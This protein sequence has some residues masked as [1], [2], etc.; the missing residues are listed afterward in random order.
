MRAVEATVVVP[1][2]L[3][4]VEARW[5]DTA[6]WADWVDGLDE[7]LEVTGPWP[8]AG[9]RVRW[10]SAPTGRGEVTEQ[11]LEHA[12]GEGQLSEVTDATAAGRQSVG[13]AE[14]G[15][16]VAVSLRLAYRVSRRSPLTPL[17]ELLFVSRAFRSSLESTL[18]R[19]ASQV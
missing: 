5:Y 12:A 9:A 2:R 18:Q 1:G 10:R 7:I 19:F 16:G 3:A 14:A 6:R 17:L 13:F 11:V 15:G 8:R 4:E